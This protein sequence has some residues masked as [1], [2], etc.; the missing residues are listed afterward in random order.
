M[1]VTSAN[2]DHVKSLLDDFHSQ[3]EL[4]RRI[5]E[6]DFLVDAVKDGTICPECLMP[7]TDYKCP[8]C[9]SEIGV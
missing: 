1:I 8:V 2:S 7:V 3:E 6:A 5:A 9:N 4:D